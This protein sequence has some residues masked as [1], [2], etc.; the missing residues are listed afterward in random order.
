MTSPHKI[1]PIAILLC[2]FRRHSANTSTGEGKRVDKKATKTTHGG[3]RTTQRVMSLIKM[4]LW[5]IFCNSIFLLGFPWSSNNITA[6]NKK[7][8][9]KTYQCIWD[10][11]VKSENR[12]EF[13]YWTRHKWQKV[14][15][16]F[17]ISYFSSKLSYHSYQQRVCKIKFLIRT[18]V[19]TYSN[20]ICGSFLI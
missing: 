11:H 10:F 4:F 8:T 9:S 14:D 12:L 19:K 13:I 18:F 1:P 7:K 17:W 16:F 5:I 20:L 2:I 15:S 3:E 6:S